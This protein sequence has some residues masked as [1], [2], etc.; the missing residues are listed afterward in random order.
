MISHKILPSLITL[1]S[2]DELFVKISIQIFNEF[3]LFLSSSNTD[4]FVQQQF[5]FSARSLFIVL[6]PRSVSMFE[7]NH[8]WTCWVLHL[9]SW[10]C[11]RSISNLWEVKSNRRTTLRKTKFKRKFYFSDSSF[12]DEHRVQSELIKTFS[13]IG[14]HAESR[15]REE[16]ILPFL[17]LIASQNSQQPIERGQ[18]KRLEIATYLFEAYSALSCC[19]HSAQS[20]LNSFLPG[21][22]CLRVDF[23]Q[24]RPDSV[25][26]LD[27]IIKDLETKLEQHR[28]D[29][30][31]DVW[32]KSN[33]NLT[34]FFIFLVLCSSLLPILTRKIFEDECSKAWPISETR[35]KNSPI[36]SSRRNRIQIWASMIK[37]FGFSRLVLIAVQWSFDNKMTEFT[38]E[39]KPQD[40][41]SF[42]FFYAEYQIIHERFSL[43]CVFWTSLFSFCQWHSI[44][45]IKHFSIVMKKKNGKICWGLFLRLFV[46]KR[47]INE[48]IEEQGKR[49]NNVDKYVEVHWDI[50]RC[51][52]E[53][54]QASADV[55][56]TSPFWMFELNRWLIIERIM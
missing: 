18:A 4:L 39:K 47:N 10:T 15:F 20:I 11:L 52:Y 32:T 46:Y 30:S 6:N 23:A 28:Q 56:V 25:A 26:V 31:I 44:A 2:D 43:F 21:L 17:A 22:Y 13:Q 45:E 49:K 7:R 1:A 35:L 33:E 41:F 19:S 27:S 51:V 38:F 3:S 9:D 12:R 48:Y 37:I 16:F 24:L 8:W 5:L 54:L 50:H 34:I 53:S 14:P 29:R 55:S 42:F 36:V 40:N